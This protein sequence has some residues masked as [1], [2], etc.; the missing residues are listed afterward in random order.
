MGFF[1]M[2]LVSGNVVCAKNDDRQLVSKIEKLRQALDDV[3]AVI[4]GAGAGMSTAAGLTYSGERFDEHF[5]DFR[6]AFGI[7]DMYSGGFYPFPDVET[8]WAWWSRH[9]YFNRYDVE[10]GRP[11]LDLL[12]LVKD[13]D[14]FV[15][16][17][18]V[19][20]QF[21]LA[22]FDKHRLFYT[23]GDYGLFQCSGP[24]SQVTYDNEEAV[25]AMMEQQKGMR[26]PSELVPTCPKC[27]RP[28]TTNLRVDGRFVEDKG[29]HAAATRYDEF[30][31]RHAGMHVLYLELGVGMNTP[32]IIKYPFWNAVDK[33]P[34]AIYACV[35]L[36][37]ACAP[38]AVNKRSILIDGDIGMVLS[39]CVS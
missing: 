27:G 1:S 29:W 35:S 33:N 9:I 16:T 18:N 39:A 36:G 31:R 34:K 20:H 11:Y 7:T 13:K 6:D 21:Q 37:E 17:T 15:I 26:I 24:C 12:K 8:L 22:G 30:C 3:D 10:P 2:P 19:D 28:M 25:R 38:K 4:V 14:Y 5:A 32:V 23:Q